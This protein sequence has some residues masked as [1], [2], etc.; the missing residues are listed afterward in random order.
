[1]ALAEPPQKQAELLKARAVLTQVQQLKKRVP[2]PPWPLDTSLQLA[3]VQLL[4]AEGNKQTAGTQLT[5]LVGS[6]HSRPPGTSATSDELL[7]N[8]QAEKLLVTLKGPLPA[9][10]PAAA[11][12][13]M[14]SAP[15]NR[16]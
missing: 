6:I 14:K 3:E 15:G 10:K 16:R 13:A 11:T 1:M 4:L 5:A 8:K 2:P 9:T 12:T 7:L